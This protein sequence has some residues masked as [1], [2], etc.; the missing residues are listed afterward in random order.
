MKRSKYYFSLGCLLF[1]A[2]IASAQ[3]FKAGDKV[4]ALIGNTWKPVYIVKALAGKSSTY[5]VR[6]NRTNNGKTMMT[7]VVLDKSK[8]RL[9]QNTTINNPLITVLKPVST[10][11]H[12]GRYELYSGIPSMYLGHLI[13]LADGRYKVAFDSE[14]DNYDESGRYT[15]NE[16][17]STI[18]W[19]SGMFKNNNW[20]GKLV[21]KEGA[22]YRIEFNKAAF[23]DSS[24]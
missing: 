1:F 5:E 21:K 6:V 2:S 10:N 23:A 16:S 20:G 19:Q 11:L 18:E 12:L 8:L 24:N 13:L 15:F 3:T 22:G 7:T 9:P 14:E 4:E 17:T